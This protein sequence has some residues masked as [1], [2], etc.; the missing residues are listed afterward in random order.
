[1]LHRT[2]ERLTLALVTLLPFHALLV[3]VLT[4]RM[5]GPEHAPLPVLA[6]WK[7]MLLAVILSC[8]VL[9]LL[10][11][12]RNPKT[13]ESL[14]AI[15]SIDILILVL[16]ALAVEPLV[17][18][19]YALPAMS[20]LLGFKYD[21]VPLVAFLVLRRVVWS[22]AFRQRVARCLLVSGVVVACYG[23]AT[24]FLPLSW[25][26]ALGYSGLHSLYLPDAPLPA[27]HQIGGT[28][29]R[30]IQSTMSGP[31]QLGMW[32]LLPLALLMTEIQN[33]QEKRKNIL[34]YFFF[35]IFS[36]AL[37]FTFSRAAWIAAFAIVSVALWSVGRNR[38][39]TGVWFLI[40]VAFVAVVALA[41]DVVLRSASSRDHWERPL[42]AVQTMIAH[43]FGLGL[44]SAGPASNRV[45]DPCVFLEDG[46]DAAWAADRADLCVFVGPVQVQPA[47][48][49]C[50]CPLLPENW[51]L[52]MGVEL[53]WA[54]MLL[55]A[56]LTVLLLLQLWRT[57]RMDNGTVRITFSMFLVLLGVSTAAL[58]LHAWEDS[59]VAYT[60]WVL[61]A[62]V[63]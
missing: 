9:E 61:L 54:G 12:Y 50:H 49:S 4:K 37:A 17:A 14:R 35:V 26:T 34:H 32:L 44:G 7:E 39:L 38:A 45:S 8:A 57:W 22:S 63:L 53:G 33:T 30:R 25:F 20:W 48:R 15:D 51:Y 56:V 3:T 24:L 5:A 11:R 16:L 43:P 29:L 47:D 10:E 36:L 19:S 41:P 60:V 21:F 40:G 18:G 13:R 2:R 55:Y 52:Q 46:A 59:A 6:L 62:T 27:F 28:M 1:M 58:F 42:T 23:I 31:N